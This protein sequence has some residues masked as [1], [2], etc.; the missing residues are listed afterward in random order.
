MVKVSTGTGNACLC[1]CGK[2]FNGVGCELRRAVVQISFVGENE[3]KHQKPRHA[4]TD[5]VAENLDQLGNLTALGVDV[6]H[7]FEE[8]KKRAQAVAA[9]MP[10]PIWS[11]PPP[12]RRGAG[13]RSSATV[14]GRSHGQGE[15]VSDI[16]VMQGSLGNW[17]TEIGSLRSEVVQ[18]HFDA[19]QD[20]LLR[21]H[22]FFLDRR[23]GHADQLCHGEDLHKLL[24][25]DSF[26]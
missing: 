19:F 18:L 12:T 6:A 17:R 5:V 13:A 9:P 16:V 7:I 15:L 24:W 3:K 10:P 25:S 14:K 2:N 23:H 11:N 20:L 21:S 4:L 1:D 22:D 8:L 26:S